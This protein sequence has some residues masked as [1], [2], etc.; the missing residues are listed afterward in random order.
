MKHGGT[1]IE[2]RDRK[3]ARGLGY[4]VEFHLR[5]AREVARGQVYKGQIVTLMN[6]LTRE[7]SPPDS[8]NLHIGF[9]IHSVQLLY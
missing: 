6:N 1:I 8:G 2:G 5:V 4:L 3:P 9:G 7:V